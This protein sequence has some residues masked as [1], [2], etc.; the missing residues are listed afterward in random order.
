MN[1]TLNKLRLTAAL[2]LALTIALILWW[3]AGLGCC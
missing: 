1:T 3:L 2:V